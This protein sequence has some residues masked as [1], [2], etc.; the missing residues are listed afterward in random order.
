MFEKNAAAQRRILVVEDDFVDELRI[1]FEGYGFHEAQSMNLRDQT[2][3][4]LQGADIA[5]AIL[6]GQLDREQTEQI[7]DGL[8]ALGIP[9]IF[10][11]THDPAQMPGYL[12]AFAMTQSGHEL[13]LIAHRLFGPP[14]YH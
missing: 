3:A 4:I 5:A 14:T 9:F 10:S 7:A 13:E 12:A 8:T 11:D 2:I 6:D 1:A